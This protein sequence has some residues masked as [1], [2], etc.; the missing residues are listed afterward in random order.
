MSIEELKNPSTTQDIIRKINEL[1]RDTSNY[2]TTSNLVTAISDESTDAEYPSA[3]LLYDKLAEKQ[4]NITGAATTVVADNLT[5]NR[6][7]I[8]NSN[9]KISVSDITSTELGYLNDVTSNVQT[10]FNNITDLIPAAASTSNELADKEFVNSSIASNTAN[11]IGTFNSV[12]ELEAYSG[13]VTNNDYAFVIN[14]VVTDNGSDWATFA[15]LDAYNKA[16][17]THFDYA[18]VVN[19]TKFDLYRFDIINQ[20]WELRATAVDKDSV[21]LNTAYNRYKATVTNNVVSWDYE[22]T[23][24]NSSFSSAQWAAINS[25]ITENDVA[26]IGTALQPNDN[27]SSLTN[28]AG[29]ISGINSS[30][31]TTA[32]GYTPQN[33]STA[34]THTASTAVGNS[35]TPVYVASNGA[36]TALSFTIAKSVPS[37]AKFTDTTYAFDTGSANGTI[38]VAVDGGT[39]TDIAVKGLGSAAYTDSTA[40]ATAAQGA[41]ADTALQSISSSDVTTAL[42]YTPYNSSNPSGYQANTI[43]AITFNNTAITPDANK[44]VNISAGLSNLSDVELSSTLTGGEG[45]VYDSTSSKWK[46][47]NVTSVIWVDWTN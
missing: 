35:T 1:A 39:A 45:L 21:A 29:Y 26:L 2:Q 10:Q 12:T 4:G 46:N 13:T 28:D 41:K 11:F 40:Y 30:D 44:T 3:K 8:S 5:A 27:V 32:L 15:A 19:G 6:A 43:E 25:G 17:L 37:D 24:N 16:L 36:A 23:L 18:W 38:S 7:L 20:E 42:G 33:S 9:G 22:Y 47:K 14:G 31:V 34:V